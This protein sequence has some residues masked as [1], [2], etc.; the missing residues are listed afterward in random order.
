MPHQKTKQKPKQKTLKE[1]GISP[2]I[3]EHYAIGLTKVN[4]GTQSLKG[5]YE[6]ELI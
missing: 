1:P 4:K 6:Q 3:S 2:G 5:L